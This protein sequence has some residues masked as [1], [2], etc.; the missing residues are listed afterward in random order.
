[1]SESK[2]TL[3]SVFTKDREIDLVNITK[4]VQKAQKIM[5]YADS[6]KCFTVENSA[7]GYEKLKSLLSREGIR[8]E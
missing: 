2:L 7:V 4:V 5:V 3:F 8:F 1:M 6:K